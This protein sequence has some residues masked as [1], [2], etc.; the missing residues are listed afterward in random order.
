VC[1]LAGV[2]VGE[3]AGLRV[4]ELAGVRVCELASLRH[5]SG[6]LA[7]N[8]TEWNS[9]ADMESPLKRTEKWRTG[10][11]KVGAGKRVRPQTSLR[12]AVARPLTGRSAL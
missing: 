7:S 5:A 9:V 1:E 3:C 6:A 10:K 2:R 4:C 11:W 12:L 8:A